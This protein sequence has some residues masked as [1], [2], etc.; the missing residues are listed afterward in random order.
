MKIVLVKL[1]HKAGEVAVLEM[2]GQDDL[3]KFLALELLS[4]VSQSR[5]DRTIPRGAFT[6]RTTKLSPSSPQRTMDA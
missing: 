5:G 1:A 3:C 4:R 2:F 6:S